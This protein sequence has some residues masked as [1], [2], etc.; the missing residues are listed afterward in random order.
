MRMR[1]R[2]LA[3]G[4]TAALLA[5]VAA[6]AVTAFGPPRLSPGDGVPTYEVERQ[7]FVRRVEADGTLRAVTA[8]PLGVPQGLR[9]VFRIAWLAADG[10]RVEAGDPVV[11]FDPTEMEE[12]MITARED[13][14]TNEL[15]IDKTESENE[16]QLAGLARDAEMAAVELESARQFQKK[17]ELIYSRNEILESEI[18][19]ELAARKKRHA[20]SAESTRRELSEAQLDLL[21]IEGRQA[22]QKI[23][24]AREGLDS[25]V[26]R[27]PHDGL[28]VFRRDWRGNM[29]RVGDTVYQGN[30]LAEIPDLSAME[31]EVYVLEADAG[32]LEEGQRAEVVLDAHPERVYQ[33]R[34]D[35]VDALAK[36][37]RRGSPVQYFAVT[38]A[39]EETDTE[40][41]K[42]GQRVRSAIEVDRAEDALVIPR[43]AVFQD[44]G[45]SV[46]FRKARGGF[47]AVPVRLGV[48]G[49]GRLVVTGGLEEGDRIALA[50]PR[51]ETAEP[52][53]GG[54]EESGGLRDVGGLLQ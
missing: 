41:M 35:R 49:M 34:V 2:S 36:P 27:A 23:H 10:S 31:A 40:R 6:V 4:V 15:R 20:E 52:A 7:T 51:A 54:S 16:G 32:G 33:A 17:D 53:G 12:Q 48:T 39:L 45:E 8:T 19:Q 38:L 42:P 44:N 21:R 5:L 28:V 22:R 46:V 11:R 50:D 26:I 14:S 13:L 37:R 25:L 30:T 29:P 1:K 24:E 18:D 9:G 3:V 47:E 43:Q